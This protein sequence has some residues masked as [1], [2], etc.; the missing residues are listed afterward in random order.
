M[1]I[2]HLVERVCACMQAS[3]VAGG[4]ESVVT[5]YMMK[6]LGLDVCAGDQPHHARVQLAGVYVHVV[7]DKILQDVPGV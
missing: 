2:W 3:A 4:R 7:D 1:S 6:L 5:D